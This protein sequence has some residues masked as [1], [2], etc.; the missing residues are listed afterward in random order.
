MLLEK[1]TVKRVAMAIDKALSAGVTAPDVIGMYL[2]PDLETETGT[3]ILDNRP[4]LKAV[5]IAP[6]RIDAYGDLLEVAP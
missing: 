2:Y 4:Q 3:F 6:P 1:H 5:T